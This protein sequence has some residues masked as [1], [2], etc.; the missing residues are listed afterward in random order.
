MRIGIMAAGAI[1]GYYGARLA[2][3]GHE[4]IFF[5]RGAHLK[6]LREHGLKLESVSG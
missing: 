2:A 5:A 3:A 6:A 1:G 4:V